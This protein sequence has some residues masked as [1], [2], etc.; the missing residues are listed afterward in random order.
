MIRT[1]TLASSRPE[2]DFPV[3]YRDC[4]LRISVLLDALE[5]EYETYEQIN[6]D[7][8]DAFNGADDCC[9][10]SGANAVAAELDR[11]GSFL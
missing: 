4:A 10:Y 7:V 3:R 11:F 9:L 5:R 1:D 6:A 8:L 2:L